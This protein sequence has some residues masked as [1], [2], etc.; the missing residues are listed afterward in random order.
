MSRRIDIELTSARPDGSWTWRAAGAREPKGVLDGSILPSGAAVGGV[1]R[2]EAESD[3]DGTRI[4]SVTDPKAKSAKGGLLELIPSDKPFEA[5]TQQ[6]AKRERG[7]RGDRDRGDRGD[8]RGPRGDRPGGDR[9]GGDR[10]RSGRPGEG[11]RRGPRS[12]R[13]GGDRPGGDRPPRGDRPGGDRPG[14]DRPGGDRRNRPHFTPPPELPQ[15]PKAK[16]LKPGKAH[17]NAV[18][19]ELSESERAVA[20]RALQGGIPAVRQA[21]KEQ[22]EQLVKDGQPAVPA[23]GLVAIAEQLLPRLRVAEWLDRADAAKADLE[24]LDLR[25]LRSVVAAGDDP[26]VARDESTRAV[27]EELKQALVAKQEKELQLWFGDIEAAL[28]VGRVIRALKLSSQPPKAGVVFPGDL[29]RRLAE[30]ATSSLDTDLVADRWSALLE[31]AA[32]SPVRAAIAPTKRPEPAGDELTATVTRL[33]SALP[34]VAAL[35]GIEPKAGAP[36]PKPLRP[37]KPTGPAK[38]AAGKVPP[39]PP[40]PAA[41]VA[42][43]PAADAPAADAPVV[44]IG[45]AE[46]QVVEPQVAADAHDV[47]ADVTPVEAVAAPETAVES[48]PEADAVEADAVA[49][50]LADAAAPDAEESAGV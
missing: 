49:A 6:L 25:D 22:N 20:E 39:P 34:Q 26:M 29:A 42:A 50:E 5:V 31:A 37:T 44:E 47:V 18:L 16:R 43:A 12:D 32:F 9:P 17:R 19:S 46:P 48:A 13:P 14:G 2:A 45:D 23:A 36:M 8:R 7:E 27:A 38:K 28:G 11:D 1:L 10:P 33:A 3:L 21:V 40:R 24:E 4:L 35:F 30:I 15:R 41:P